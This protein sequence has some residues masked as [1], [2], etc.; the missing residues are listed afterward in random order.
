MINFY[1]SLFRDDQWFL[2]VY[3]ERYPSEADIMKAIYDNEADCAIVEK[4]YE[5]LPFA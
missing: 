4:R 2:D 3:C 1:I 5:K